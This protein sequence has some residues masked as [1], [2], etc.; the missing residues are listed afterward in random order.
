MRSKRLLAFLLMLASALTYA[1]QPATRLITGIVK[2]ENGNFLPSITVAEKS[3]TNYVIANE[4]GAFSIR[5]KE[6]AVLTFTSVGF[7]S[8]TIS[9]DN[10]NIINIT[11]KG[12]SK[13]LGEV[14]VVGYG[15]QKKGNLT[16][17]VAVVKGDELVNRPTATVSQA[18]QGKV[19]GM[20]FSAGSFGFEPG[21]ALSLQIRG[22]GSPL[23][24]VDGI[25]TSNIN[26]LN[27]NDI[28]SVTV[29]KDAAAAA[30]YGARA[31]YGVVLITTKSGANNNKLSVEYSGNY[32]RIK[33]IRM[34]HHLDSYTTALALNEAAIN[35]GITPLF[36]NATIDRILAYQKDP[37]NTAET[38]PA[39]ANPALWAN[40][41]E[42]NANYDWFDVFYGDGQRYQHNLSMSGGNKAVS[43]FLS[44]GYV[45]DGG[46]L[47]VGTDNYK[48]YNLSARFDASLT[49][50]MKVSSNTRYYQSSRNVPAYDNQG[51]YDLLFHQVART[52]PTQY[53]NSKYGVPSIQSKI[54][55]TR[56][57]GNNNTTINDMVQRFAVEITP[58]K[59][60][61]INGDYT[62]DLTSNQF[63]SKNFT[64]YEDN[65]AGQPVLSGSTSPSSVSKSQAIT[66]YQSANAY[67]TY[68]FKI[69]GAHNFSVM[70]GYQ[71]EKSKLSSL[72]AS[73][74]NMIT[75][76]VPTLNTS[77]GIINATDNLNDYAT[78]GVFGRLSYNFDE[79]YLFEFNS[80]Y[81]G[82]FKF[83]EGK[84]WGF[85]PSVSAGWN[86]AN[87]K[88]WEDI[89]PVVNAFKV[90]GSYGSLGNQLTALPYQD[91]SLLGV[92]ANLGWILNGS[93]PSFTSAPT[94]VNPDVTWET[95]N[96]KNF[97]V[98]LGLL[99]NRL[100]LTGE[101]YQRLSFDQLGPAA[102]VPG[103]IG[104]ATLPQAN[105]MET[106][107]NGWELS[108][109]WSDKIGS[110]FKYSVVGQV[111]DYQ[112][113]I[114]KYNNPTK[115]LTTAYEGQRQGEIWGYTSEGLILDKATADAINSGST[116]KAISGQAWKIGDMRYADLNNDGVVNPGD[117]TVTNSGDRRVIGNTTPRY[118]FGA[119][120][121]AEWK[122]FDFS[123]FWQ[124][125]GKRDLVLGDNLFWGFTTQVQSSIFKDHLNYFR[126][127][128]ATKY[129]GLGQNTNAYFAR[130]YLDGP[131]NAKNQ[132]TQT[133]FVQN[134]AYARLKNIQLGYSLPDGLTQRIKL[135]G[136]YVYVSG[137]NLVTFTDLPDHFDPEVANIGVR[138][139]G[140]SFFPQ[141]AF[142]FGVNL[143]F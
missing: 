104:V 10:K 64:V 55:W 61:T 68:K 134:A 85:F 100:T 57:A 62:F 125:V 78:E 52:F 131:M 53:M 9:I 24:L 23:I 93:R 80:R 112:T 74:T 143:K 63:T 2:D 124:G 135:R 49:D 76:E 83:A 66:F 72:T 11:L 81:D 126:D 46:V 19:S 70:A 119:T 47:Q 71:Q 42:S 56:D 113:T 84:K 3:T 45:N 120:F 101:I 91:I 94:L 96:T 109:G 14:V 43:F 130:P 31:S 129:A 136:V 123:M 7:E 99:R 98:D 27:P 90:R 103:V 33:P 16:G 75:S 132:A 6:N 108:F 122:G 97:G 5:V 140:K 28:E 1:Q 116:Q 29:L 87:E 51:D 121:Q 69:G 107:T 50:W 88:F 60:W 89:K 110:D 40:A 22:Q 20:N 111:F 95:S 118:Q 92:N 25:Y 59:G 65:V 79:R 105:N 73:K 41:F 30:I 17:A 141:E 21:A 77:T 4:K 137:E 32:S 48:R 38:V 58:M 12:E 142:T 67:T 128:D 102:A 139:S 15:T 133:R 39:A 36:T 114:T 26:G 44:G 86:I 13:G 37:M 138:G 117:N 115:I 127:A 106:K 8:Q 54:P 35:S 82:T 18:M 34:P